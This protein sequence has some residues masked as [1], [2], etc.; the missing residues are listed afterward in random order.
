MTHEFFVSQRKLTRKGM[1]SLAADTAACDAFTIEFDEEWDG[2]VKLVVLQN[3]SRT[4]QVFYTGKTALPRQVCGRGDLY[5]T[6]YG[7]RKKGDTAAV[8]QTQP[9]IRPVRIVGSTVPPD[10]QT[11]PYT[12]SAFDQMAAEVAN[13]RK[14]AEQAEAVA[15]Q[16]LQ[17]KEEGVFQG[18]AGQAATVRVDSVRKGSPAMVENLGTARNAVLRFTLPY[19]DSLTQE[20]ADRICTDLEQRLV[21][22]L[23]TALEEIRLLQQQYIEEVAP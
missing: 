19:Q 8:L 12:P 3:G 4:A 2:L 9:M 10:N 18:P 1:S 6:C 13:A 11:Q 5:L 23:E 7:Y 20:D 17:W 21:G 15:R 16:M 14:V 22:D